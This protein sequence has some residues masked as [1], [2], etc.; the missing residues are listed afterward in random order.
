MRE[1]AVLALVAGQGVDHELS[2]LWIFRRANYLRV[3]GSV[4]NAWH[5]KN[6][7]FKRLW[8]KRSH[9]QEQYIL[10]PCPSPRKSG[11]LI[12]GTVFL[13]RNGSSLFRRLCQLLD[14]ECKCHFDQSGLLHRQS[15][16]VCRIQRQLLGSDSQR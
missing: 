3:G 10:W 2:P 4:T 11:S 7:L 8:Q 14:P 15:K 1:C 6:C 16:T 13:L 9:C 12:L 5:S